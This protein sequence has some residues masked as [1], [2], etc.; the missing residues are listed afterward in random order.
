M[1]KQLLINV[2]E[3]WLKGKNR[4]QYFK[5]LRQHIQLQMKRLGQKGYTI[6]NR[7]QRFVLNFET[8]YSDHVIPALLK[9]AGIYTIV[10]VL[11]TVSEI[12]A[13]KEAAL[14]V[15]GDMKPGELVT[16]RVSTDRADKRFPMPSME[17]SRQIGG[18][19]LKKFDGQ[20]K[21]ELRK[22]QRILRVRVTAFGTYVSCTEYEGMGGLPVGTS[23]HIITMLS[24]GFDSPVASYLMSKRGCRQ[25]FAFFHAFPFVG[26]EVKEKLLQIFGKLAE[27]QMGCELYVIPYG[28]IQKKLAKLCKEEYRTIFFRQY[29][30]F[31]SN[32]LARKLKARALCTGDSLGQ[33]S[34]QTLGNMGELNKYSDRIILRPLVGYNKREIIALSKVA[35]THDISIIPH[36]DAC[37]LF[38]P[39]KPIIRP[40]FGY[41]EDF[42]KENP[43]S[44]ELEECVNN[45]QIY[46]LDHSG[47]V[48]LREKTF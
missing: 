17:I 25:S 45:A 10:P 42:V 2:D 15:W 37:S 24:G 6:K 33:V 36:D 29:M 28:E 9:V 27:Y 7:N 30:V 38:A 5:A 11:E 8:P 48:S 32:L 23:G 39:K 26:D 40:D 31:A 21:V 43:M 22:P 35:E 18:A 19:L 13:I 20:L 46:Y 1:Y 4:P 41:W 44:E 3:L 16:F 12:D 47:K 34:S 14:E